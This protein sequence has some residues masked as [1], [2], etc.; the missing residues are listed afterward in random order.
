M[1]SFRLTT[2]LFICC[3]ACA[4]GRQEPAPAVGLNHIAFMVKNLDASRAFY[5]QIVG[6][7]TL[8]EPF[9]DG[10]HCWLRIA[11]TA[12]LHLIEGPYR[13]QSIKQ[14]HVCFTVRSV[15][16]FV[17][18]LQKAG[19]AFEDWPGNKQQMTTRPDGVHQIYLQDPDG[20]WLEI[21]D[22]RE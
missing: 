9:R 17:Q 4:S 20:Y 18:Q 12:A 10:L 19:I 7:D 6:L 11:P 14:S 15:P 21:N 2:L 16:A 13:Q 22:A 3:T 5:T 8:P 1:F